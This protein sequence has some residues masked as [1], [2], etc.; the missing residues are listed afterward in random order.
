MFWY[1]GAL[2]DFATLRDRAAT[3]GR[4][5][6]FGILA[7]G[8]RNSARHWAAYQS[9]YTAM[10][11]LGV[12]LVVSVHSVVGLDFAAGLMPGW[13]ETIFPPYF[14]VGAMYSGFAMVV[15]LAAVVRRAL[16]LQALILPAHF[17]VLGKVLLFGAL[18]MALSYGSEWVFAWY[19]QEPADL[20]LVRWEFLGVYGPVYLAMLA[21]NC[22]VPQLLWLPAV[23]RTPGLIVPVAILVNLGMWLERVLIVAVT[24]ARGHLPSQWSVFWPTLWD[25]LLLA[26]SLG[27]FALLFLLFLRLLPAASMHEIKARLHQEAAP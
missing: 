15:V 3:R 11:A 5:V 19:A 24:P 25:W 20:F 4:Q 8:W 26:G 17:D 2:P 1:A 6:A 16:D 9:Y 10:A 12:P 23:R 14:V 27:F 21:C 18:V 13:Q 22:A 7:M